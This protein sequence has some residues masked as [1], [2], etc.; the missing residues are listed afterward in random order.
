MP[1]ELRISSELNEGMQYV[2]L[3]KADR[4][5]KVQVGIGIMEKYRMNV[6][7]WICRI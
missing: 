1:E 4:E 6:C 7:Q 3:E 2:G 5:Q